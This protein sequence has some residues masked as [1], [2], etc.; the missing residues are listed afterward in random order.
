M[1]FKSLL[2]GVVWFVVCTQYTLWTPTPSHGNAHSVYTYNIVSNSLTH[3]FESSLVNIYGVWY[4]SQA[5]H[6]IEVYMYRGTASQGT[7]LSSVMDLNFDTFFLMKNYRDIQKHG[8]DMYQFCLLN[9]KVLVL[10]IAK[11]KHLH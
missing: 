6:T 5:P 3:F 9:K 8:Y 10:R 11:W 2:S 4:A 1:C 7:Y